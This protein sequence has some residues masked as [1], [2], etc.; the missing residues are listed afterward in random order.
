MLFWI[1]VWL[2][3]CN[4][5]YASASLLK[6]CGRYPVDKDNNFGACVTQHTIRITDTRRVVVRLASI[7]GSTAAANDFLLA[8]HESEYVSFTKRSGCIDGDAPCRVLLESTNIPV[9]TAGSNTTAYVGLH[10]SSDIWQQ[11]A[12]VELSLP[13]LRL[14]MFQ[15]RC[16][17]ACSSAGIDM[18]TLDWRRRTE[19]TDETAIAK[20][21]VII[22]N[23]THMAIPEASNMR[24]SNR[25]IP[26]SLAAGC[27]IAGLLLALIADGTFS[28]GRPW[29]P[30]LHFL[31]LSAIPLVFL[32]W[33]HVWYADLIR[34][35]EAWFYVVSTDYWYTFGLY[36]W[37][38][39]PLC[40][41]LSVVILSATGWT[42]KEVVLALLVHTQ[43]CV[44]LMA[45]L[46]DM[47]N[48]AMLVY[49]TVMTLPMFQRYIGWRGSRW[50]KHARSVPLLIEGM[51]TVV[52]VVFTSTFGLSIIF[53]CFE[54]L[55]RIPT[56]LSE[57]WA[58]VLTAGC[59]V[60][61]L[62]TLGRSIVR[63]FET[64]T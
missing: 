18:G 32:N 39:L 16:R 34:N 5:T 49:I 57:D 58:Y 61:E 6:A 40:W 3:A 19:Q 35:S 54:T 50:G 15:H 63:Q 4:L 30:Y 9:Q 59:V 25:P 10:P 37:L 33:L 29:R 56:R 42:Y 7:P 36:F 13:N 28:A 44:T 17:D 20:N 47:R 22:L 38:I 60:S 8:P 53:C 24:L 55:L 11:M 27:L 23:Q 26:F 64:K 51:I 12:R 21:S 48:E 41:T 46:T 62:A 1:W 2:A 31:L 14:T 52:S 43:L 45:C